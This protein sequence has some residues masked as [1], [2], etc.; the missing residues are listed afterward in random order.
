MRAFV[1]AYAPPS[2]VQ[3]VPEIHLVDEGMCLAL[4]GPP[5]PFH[6]CGARGRHDGDWTPFCGATGRRVFISGPRFSRGGLAPSSLCRSDRGV[7]RGE[8]F[9]PLGRRA[10]PCRNSSRS[11][12]LVGCHPSAAVTPLGLR[13]ASRCSLRSAADHGPGLSREMLT[14]PKRRDRQSVPPPRSSQTSHSLYRLV[15]LPDQPGSD[16]VRVPVVIIG[17][18]LAPRLR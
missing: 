5:L 10:I 14:P 4:L 7:T 1:R 17:C 9:Q 8:F 15:T 2:T 11:L 18:R 3:I 16:D 6:G 12:V 13:L